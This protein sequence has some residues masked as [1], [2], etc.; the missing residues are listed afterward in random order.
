MGICCGQK[1]PVRSGKMAAGA[2]A[3]TL[4]ERK[5]DDEMSQYLRMMSISLAVLAV[6]C[7][8]NVEINADSDTIGRE[9]EQECETE[10]VPLGATWVV[11][12]G[13]AMDFV[14]LHDEMFN[15]D[16]SYHI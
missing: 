12:G 4:F 7:V 9:G 3:P 16:I 6:I 14:Y 15:F 5:G 1:R 13:F 8:E 11:S 10:D 2:E